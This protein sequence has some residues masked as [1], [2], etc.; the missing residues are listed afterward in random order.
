ME[1]VRTTETSGYFIETT[2]RYILK[3][4]NLHTRRH[5]NLKS[6]NIKMNLRDTDCEYG[7]WIEL[8]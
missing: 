7:K 4:C 2:R 8:A 5:E 1:A 3:G 6:H